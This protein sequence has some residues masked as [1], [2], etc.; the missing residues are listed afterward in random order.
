MFVFTNENITQLNNLKYTQN[1]PPHHTKKLDMLDDE[2]FLFKDFDYG[3][4]GLTP[5]PQNASLTTYYELGY[6]QSLPEDP[7]LVEYY[8]D[9]PQVFKDVCMENGIEY[10]K[11]LVKFLKKQSTPIILDLKYYYNR[12]RPF[13]LAKEYGIKLSNVEMESMNTPSYPSGHSTQG[14]LI[15]Y[16]LSTKFNILNDSFYRAA[17]KISFSRNIARAHFPSDSRL[18]EQLGKKMFKHI[19]HKI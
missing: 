4:F 18:G 19:I 1:V 2:D 17:K 3:D 13:Q 7:Q 9:I 8:D 6:L 10:P 16:V 12:P 5:P 14:Y 15:A 11:K